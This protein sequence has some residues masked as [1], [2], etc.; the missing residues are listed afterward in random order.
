MKFG[1]IGIA[2]V[3]ALGF[4]VLTSDPKFWTTLTPEGGEKSSLGL[5]PTKY[6]E[7]EELVDS[8]R[9]LLW[10]GA[11]HGLKDGPWDMAYRPLS[12]AEIDDL[13]VF[14]R[15]RKEPFA[16]EPESWDCDNFALEFFYLSQAWNMRIPAFIRPL[17]PAV[18]VA[19]VEVNGPYELFRRTTWA[20]FYHAINVVLRDDGQWL[21]FEPQ[22]GKMMPIDGP[23]FEGVIE[24]VKIIL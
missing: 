23:V 24:V 10:P 11:S 2:L 21:F 1:L 8:M 3:F 22:N 13:L 14:W 6:V 20:H 9:A 17:P 18:G 12:Q 16:Y 7:R 19:L 4:G 15:A 5:D